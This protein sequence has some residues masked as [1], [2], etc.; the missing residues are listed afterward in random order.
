MD[1]YSMLLPIVGMIAIFYF[2]MIRPQNQQRKKHE[3]MVARIKRG[4]KVILQG[5][6]YGRV[7]HVGEAVLNVEIAPDVVVEQVKSM[8]L[9]VEAK[10]EPQAKKDTPKQDEADAGD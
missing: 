5:G 9:S 2:L 3:E 6:I 8:V 4:D 10:P 1:N 7:K